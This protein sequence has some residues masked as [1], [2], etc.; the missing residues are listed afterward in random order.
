MPKAGS[1]RGASTSGSGALRRFAALAVVALAWCLLLELVLRIHNPLDLPQRGWRVVLPVDKRLVF[2]NPKHSPK[3]QRQI[4]VTYNSL[5]FRGPE[6]PED[7]SERFAILTL[8]G[9][10][11]HSAR[12]S[13]GSSWPDHVRR[14]LDA[15]FSNLWLNN[16]GMEGHSTFGHLSLL[17]QLVVDLHP[18]L[19]AF[20]VGINDRALETEREFDAQIRVSEA[21][22]IHRLIARSEVLA[23]ALV[24]VRR[25]RAQSLGLMHWEIDVPS[26]PDF[27]RASEDREAVLARHRERYLEPY[28]HRLEQLLEICEKNGIE[29][30]LITQPALFG[31]GP[32]P[33]TG[34]EL[35]TL[36][37]GESSS[38]LAWAVL[39]LYNGVT[40]S[41]G[42][43]HGVLVIDLARELPKDSAYFYDWA[44][45]SDAGAERVGE[46]VSQHLIRHL[47]DRPGVVRGAARE[48]LAR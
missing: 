40:R 30:M 7:R 16:A 3:L 26:Q 24:L 46:I 13:D 41:V 8:G 29:P 6:P 43:S 34:R 33:T 14:A 27:E 23:T 38:S 32:D 25:H 35:G 15:E 18:D 19:I 39:E 28:R 5:G 12:Q 1:A 22:W 47:R 48:A 10:T 20:L 21:S 45:F 44:H 36:S 37:A 11:T 17:S 42:Q 9:S 31:D 4:T 2:E